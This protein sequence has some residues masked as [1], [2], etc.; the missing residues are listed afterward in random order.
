[1]EAAVVGGPYAEIVQGETVDAGNQDVL[2][3]VAA[4]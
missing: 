3:A 2:G 1:M 4:P